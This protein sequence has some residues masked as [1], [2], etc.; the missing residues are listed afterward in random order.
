MNNMSRLALHS[1]IAA[2]LILILIKAVFR[3]PLTN[4]T[5]LTSLSVRLWDRPLTP[6][7]A[8]ETP[9][10]GY[11]KSCFNGNRLSRCS[12]T[13]TVC[14][15]LLSS[16][17]MVSTI[18]ESERSSLI[19]KC[20]KKTVNSP[21]IEDSI[22]CG[23]L[24]ALQHCHFQKQQSRCAL[25]NENSVI[26]VGITIKFVRYIKEFLLGKFKNDY[27]SAPDQFNQPKEKF[28]T[29]Q[30][31]TLNSSKSLKRTPNRLRYLHRIYDL[32]LL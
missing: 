14:S 8:V 4:R 17:L 24:E 18:P 32:W 6:D 5:E 23:G 3:F 30:A 29:P 31:E 9:L 19:T 26:A 20:S 27:E 28:D 1:M 15:R 2:T 21:W 12:Q 13:L 11:C 22:I 16:G 10:S 7:G 25:W